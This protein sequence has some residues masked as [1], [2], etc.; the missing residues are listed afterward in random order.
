MKLLGALFILLACSG[1]G[2]LAGE[3]IAARPKQLQKLRSDLTW[4]EM[5]INYAATPLPEALSKLAHFSDEPVRLL[6]QGM[7]EALVSG[8]GLTA[9]EAWRRSL[10]HFRLQAALHESDLAVL[11]DFGAG[12]GTT[13]RQEQLKK[14][15]LLQ[16]QLAALQSQAEEARH[17]MERVYRTMG[18][19][20][21]IAL[22]I[23]L[24]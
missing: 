15:K 17:K 3:R 1:L 2:M 20:T 22:I 11:R 16:E 9:E 8:E 21:G 10:E 14:F 18:V 6:W 12:L 24:F 13:N 23:L 5:D 7:W 19:L 4:L